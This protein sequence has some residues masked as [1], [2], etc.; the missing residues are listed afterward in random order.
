MQ[1]KYITSAN[2]LNQNYDTQVALAVRSNWAERTKYLVGTDDSYYTISARNIAPAASARNIPYKNKVVARNQNNVY[3]DRSIDMT[4]TANMPKSVY[5]QHTAVSTMTNENIIKIERAT[6]SISSDLFSI[7]APNYT[8]YRTMYMNKHQFLKSCR[9]PI[10]LSAMITV[11]GTLPSGFIPTIWKIT[12]IFGQ[13]YSTSKFTV[14][15]P[16]YCIGSGIY[17]VTTTAIYPNGNQRA[18]VYPMFFSFDRT[19]GSF[20][21]Q[22]SNC[23]PS[24]ITHLAFASSNHEYNA[25]PTVIELGLSTVLYVLEN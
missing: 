15:G 20:I 25:N 12:S 11:S 4:T 5:F 7:S 21:W 3:A 10:S 1:Y 17:P 19:T 16:A 23:K 9:V 18:D 22:R 24:T 8:E 14:L 2:V 13:A 6:N